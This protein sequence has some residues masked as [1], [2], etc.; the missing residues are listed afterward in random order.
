MMY[1]RSSA[2]PF[3]FVAACL[4]VSGASSEL[5]GTPLYRPPDTFLTGPVNELYPRML[6]GFQDA[7]N[8]EWPQTSS[9][10]TVPDSQGS[11]QRAIF[12][13]MLIGSILRFLISATVRQFARET[14]NPMNWSSYQ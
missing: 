3:L 10:D 4:L 2:K 5:T 11:L 7:I 1:T 8:F 13:T 14:F 6:S 12:L 9:A